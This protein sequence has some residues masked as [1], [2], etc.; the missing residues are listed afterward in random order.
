MAL[1]LSEE[2]ELLRR[3]AR[4]FLKEHAPVAELRR[5]RDAQDP[6]GFS[7]ELWKQMAELGWAGIPFPEELG[8]A[9][10][11]LVELGI[12][13][14]ECG[15]TLAATPLVSSVLACGSALLLGGT[16]AQQQDVL[17]A[18]AKGERIVALALQEG[19]R[20][21]PHAVATR[22]EAA[23]QG[24]FRITGQKGFV[25]DGHVAD[26]LLVVA[27]SAG[28]P[29]ER[30]GLSLF[31]VDRDAKGVSVARTIMVDGRNAARVSLEGVEV[32]AGALVGAAGRGADVLDP[33]LD[34][35]AAGLAAE[36]LGSSQEAYERTLRYLKTRQQFGVPIG[37][38]QALKHRASRL[39]VALEL[40]RSA[41]LEALQ[42]LDAGDAHAS[43]RAS[44]AKALVSDASTLVA[45]EG[46]QMHGGIGVTDEEDIGLFLK[47]ARVAQQSFGDAAFHRD[48]FAAL[49]GY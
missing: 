44:S 29:G 16:R 22:A 45:N 27:R 36:L 15:R 26:Q 1:V 4:E 47:R 46:V 41:V 30:E 3:T 25:L 17:P 43:E 33:T 12:V 9:G 42:A 2:Q 35:A 10:L 37:S 48:R 5:L 28:R 8:G 11:G 24:G 7:R 34:R 20:H 14:E 18:I 19:P 23:G 6:V 40:A 21:A 32:P 38:F 13:L 39:Y 49:R 31:L